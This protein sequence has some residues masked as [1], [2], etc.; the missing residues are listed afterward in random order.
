[1][2]LT[3]IG[4]VRVNRGGGLVYD[5]YVEEAAVREG[6]RLSMLSGDRALVQIAGTTLHLKPKR[7]VTGPTVIEG[8]FDGGDG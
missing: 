2:S 4:S 5:I 8:G 3:F 7:G 6:V 1:M